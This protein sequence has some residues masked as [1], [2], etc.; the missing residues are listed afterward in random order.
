MFSDKV[1]IL[2]L[3]K[4]MFSL[5]LFIVSRMV[6]LVMIYNLNLCRIRILQKIFEGIYVS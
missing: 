3:W 1:A 4:S 5:I 2:H 6:K